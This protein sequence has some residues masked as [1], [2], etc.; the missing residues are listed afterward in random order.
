MMTN[1]EYNTDYHLPVLLKESV[2]ALQINPSGVYVDLTFGGGGHSREILSR[3]NADGRLIGFDQDED[4]VA[5]IPADEPR[6]QLLKYNFRVLQRALR[7][8]GHR[9]VDGILADLGVSSFQFDTAHRGFSYRFEAEL[10]M[11]MNQENPRTAQDILQTYTAEQL[12]TM[13]SQLGE[14][15]NART[16]AQ[17]IVQARSRKRIKTTQE[18]LALLEKFIIGPKYKY[19]GQVFQALRMEVNEELAA[20]RE[21]L[22]QTASVI[23]PGGILSVITYHSLEDRLVKNWIRN[24]NFDSEPDR[25]FYG[26]TALPFSST[27]KKPIEPSKDEQTTN[28][29][30]HSARLRVAVRN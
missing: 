21:M 1:E 15:R 28:S 8:V 13:F 6:F 2:D 29:R 12:Q 27:I 16:L 14:V 19:L 24:G 26:N 23:R 5:N 9:Q 17:G 25:D 10:D 3:L 7:L 22:Q 20:L 11:R 18:L 30:A 4:A